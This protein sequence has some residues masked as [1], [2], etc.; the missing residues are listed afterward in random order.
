MNL[1]SNFDFFRL[2]SYDIV[3]LIIM[4]FPPSVKLISNCLM[5]NFLISLFLALG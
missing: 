5:S 2:T 4:C 1:F 3:C